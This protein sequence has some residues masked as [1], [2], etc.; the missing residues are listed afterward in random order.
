MNQVSHKHFNKHKKHH[1]TILSLTIIALI[2]III[3]NMQSFI[4]YTINYRDNEMVYELSFPYLDSYE[5][6]SLLANLLPCISLLRCIVSKSKRFNPKWYY[7]VIVCAVIY[8]A[9]LSIYAYTLGVFIFTIL[10]MVVFVIITFRTY[11]GFSKWSIKK[12]I[13]ILSVILEIVYIPIAFIFIHGGALALVDI[14]TYQFMMSGF[15]IFLTALL[16]Y[17]VNHRTPEQEL[18]VLQNKY[19]RGLIPEHEYQALRA[20]I[21]SKL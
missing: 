5:L 7:L 12:T 6:M 14:L 4:D 3:G 13:T 9:L 15:I 11:M 18:R 16:L 17:I 10:Q 21:I 8:S 2:L 19:K 1:K 20:Y